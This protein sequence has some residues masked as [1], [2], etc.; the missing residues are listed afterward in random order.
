MN[1]NFN[2]LAYIR[3]S[4][5]QQHDMAMNVQGQ[6]IKVYCQEHDIAL[7]ETFT[8]EGGGFTFEGETWRDMEEFMY[9]NKG[10]LHFLIV[11]SPDRI[12][13]DKK[14]TEALIAL[15]ELKYNI[16]VIFVSEH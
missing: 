13:R 9:A 10:A 11:H 16:S 14:I 4:L 8:D 5:P 2:A 12:G 1:N 15:L 7:L 6:A 3:Y